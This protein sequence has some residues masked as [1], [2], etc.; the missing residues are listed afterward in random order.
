MLHD[1]SV[2]CQECIAWWLVGVNRWIFVSPDG[3]FID[4]SLRAS[5]VCGH[6][7]ER[8]PSCV[9]ELDQIQEPAELQKH[10]GVD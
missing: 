7:R 4:A 2:S 3:T 9:E 5:L 6:H 10:A 8:Y 1:G